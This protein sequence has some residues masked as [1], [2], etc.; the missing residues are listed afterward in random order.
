MVK[1][2]PIKFFH[3][4]GAYGYL[5]NFSDH[6]V[7]MDHIEWLTAEHAYQAQKFISGSEWYDLIRDAKTP[8]EVKRLSHR[9]DAPLREDWIEIKVSIMRQVIKAKFDQNPDILKKLLSSGSRELIEDSYDRF[10][11]NGKNGS[12]ENQLGRV[13]MEYRDLMQHITLKDDRTL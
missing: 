5:S 1:L 3:P 12:G 11:G 2:T 7:K 6:L 10:W 13:L 9:P 8:N 4:R